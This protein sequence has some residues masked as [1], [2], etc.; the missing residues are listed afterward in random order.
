MK[1]E[2]KIGGE[3]EAEG[4][5]LDEQV[6]STLELTA[7]VE[8]LAQQGQR[9]AKRHATMFLVALR[10][11]QRGEFLAGVQAFFH[12]LFLVL[13]YTTSIS[14]R[15]IVA[16]PR[17]E[18]KRDEDRKERKPMPSFAFASLILPGKQE[19]WRRFLQEMLEFRQ[20]EHE[21]SRRR[22]G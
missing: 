20:S 2:I 11:E 14:G 18:S 12:A 4:F 21:E 8:G 5:P 3:V 10:P 15:D 22:L 9:T 19:A 6:H 13:H 1:V 7:F 17:A 16:H